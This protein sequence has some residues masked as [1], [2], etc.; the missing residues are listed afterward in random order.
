MIVILYG[1]FETVMGRYNDRI[2]EWVVVNEP[3]WWGSEGGLKNSVWKDRISEDYIELAFRKARDVAPNAV[4]I[5]NEVGVDY[6]G[7][8][9]F[10]TA[11]EDFYNLVKGLVDTGVPI[12]AVGFEFHLTIPE[13]SWETEPTVDKIVAN[14]D[15]YGD[16]G[17]DVL[18]TE[19]DV[20]IEEPI[21]QEKLETQAE[22]YAIVMEAVLKSDSSRSIS[23]W[24]QSDK[25]SWITYNKY[26]WPNLPDGFLGY[27]AACMYDENH[28]PKP[29]YY[30]VLEV[31]RKNLR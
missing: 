18:I 20:K 23:V 22:V 6:V 28:E 25:Y 3:I 13:Y 5:L 7:Q 14:F 10:G 12:D 30:S 24:G 17:L 9:V 1:Y 15:L 27:S 26:H 11:E 29:A 21:T 2:D 31:L 19:L 8:K 16:L 4:L